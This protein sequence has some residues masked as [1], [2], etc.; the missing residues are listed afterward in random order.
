M[1][2]TAIEKEGM[3]FMIDHR[4]YLSRRTFVAGGALALASI[5]FGGTLFGCAPD[6]TTLSATEDAARDASTISVNKDAVEDLVV[7]TLGKDIKIACIVIAAHEGFYEEEKLNVTFE[8]VANLSDGITA[9]SQ[10][11]L[12]VLPFGIIP[13]CTFVGQGTENLVVFGGTIAQGSECVTLPE[14]EKKYVST[15]DFKDTKIA[16]FPMETGHLVMQGLLDDI[17]M[18]N[19][20]NW[21][22][23]S[24]QQAII[25]AVRNGECD[26]GFL[27]SG[28][29]YVAKQSGLVTSMHVG[30]LKPDF[31]CCRQSTSTECLRD[32]T[33]ALVKFEIANLRA[34]EVFRTDRER[35][36]KA[37]AA[38]SGQPETYVENVMYGT[39]EYTTP[40]IV[41]MDPYTDAVCAFYEVMKQTENIDPATP[42]RMEDH[43]DSTVYKAA[44]DEM[45]ARGENSALYAELLKVYDAHNTIGK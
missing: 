38:H 5:G 3:F 24:G 39:D 23:M 43:V 22:I 40:M 45:I 25:E 28:Q 20:D 9:V 1:H 35:A 27:N 17:G 30:D 2:Q 33:S 21:I 31:P 15:A 13:T 8:T 37:L 41:E 6:A 19:P 7:A 16:Y 44:L 14:N 12:D 34:Y 26:C 4:S 36:I 11:K 29:G 18:Y 42:Y 32:K 10:N